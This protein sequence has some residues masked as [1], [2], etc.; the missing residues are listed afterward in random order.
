MTDLDHAL[1]EPTLATMLRRRNP[2][3][4]IYKV[5][6]QTPNGD[7]LRPHPNTFFLSRGRFL[8]LY[9]YDEDF[10][11]HYGHDDPMFWRWQRQNGTRFLYLPQH[12]HALYLGTKDT[13]H[14]HSLE[15]NLAHNAKLAA[16]KKTAWRQFGPARGHS[17]RFLGFTWQTVLDRP[18]STPTPPAKPNRTWLHT[19]WWR[20]LLPT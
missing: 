14:D 11:G 6:R 3:R 17:R 9:G 1:P 13:P 16:T 10:C 15:R 12:C 5:R 2:G 19:W 7:I 18:R 4:T 20:W 8:R